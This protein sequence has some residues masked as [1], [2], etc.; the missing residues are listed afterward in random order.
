MGRLR[1]NKIAATETGDWMSTETY[2]GQTW[3]EPVTFVRQLR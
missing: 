2:A 1:S 3:V